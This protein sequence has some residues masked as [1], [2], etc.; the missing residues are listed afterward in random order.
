MRKITDKQQRVLLAIDQ[1]IKVAGYPPTRREIATQIGAKYPS[2]VDAHLGALRAKGYIDFT[3]GLPRSLRLTKRPGRTD[4]LL[5]RIEGYGGLE[6]A[7]EAARVRGAE[8]VPPWIANRFVP[9]PDYFIEVQGDQLERA[10]LS[11]GDIVAVKLT[12]KA[13]DGSIVLVRLGIDLYWRRMRYN[14][15]W[16]ELIPESNNDMHRP[17]RAGNGPDKAEVVAVVLGK[18]VQHQALVISA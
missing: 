3:P 1:L 6:E 17:M 5:I 4:I 7:S 13:P 18:L 15:N 14:G 16:R 11:N 9:I 2:T 12:T 8:T 10:E